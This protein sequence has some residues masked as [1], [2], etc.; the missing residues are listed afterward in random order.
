MNYDPDQYPHKLSYMITEGGGKDPHTGKDIPA[1]L[2]WSELL[3][4]RYDDI[5]RP[6]AKTMPDMKIIT[7]TYAV[8]MP[9][10][11]LPLKYGTM[12]R[13]FNRFGEQIGE[14]AC[15][16]FEPQSENSRLWV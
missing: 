15:K 16:R 5:K 4:C 3:P 11:R 12:I 7:E 2:S 13:L 6:V 8:Y 10:C 1:S 9:P 14:W